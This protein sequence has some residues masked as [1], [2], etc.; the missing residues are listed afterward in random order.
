[1]HQLVTSCTTVY[2]DG[3][4]CTTFGETAEF[5]YM[6]PLCLQPKANRVGLLGGTFNPVHNGHISMAYIAL[7][8]FLLGEV[9]F[10]P[11]GQPPH[12]QDEYIAAAEHRLNMLRLATEGES[13]F[14]VDTLELN[15]SGF[16]YTVDT[17][18][19]LRRAHP[20]TE[21]Y[22]I[23]GADTLYELMTWKNFERVI[24]L[25][26]FICVLRPGLDDAR[27]RAYAQIMNQKYGDRI[28]V[29]QDKG[30]D[31]S[32]SLIRRL[33]ADNRLASGLLPDSVAEY[34][35][36]NRVYAQGV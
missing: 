17:L 3:M 13:R 14:S 7:Y 18:E 29:A 19:A 21:Y 9:V 8:E 32:S 10:I 30:P 2:N 26:Y 15:R 23:I 31:I 11:L 22:Y 20:N 16:T 6:D 5:S 12:K 36:K 4:N 1:M 33:A 24:T 28:H 35:R 25:T 34:I 27:V